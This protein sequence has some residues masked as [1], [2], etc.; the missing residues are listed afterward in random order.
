MVYP[1]MMI[2]LPASEWEVFGRMS[3][4]ELANYLRDWAGRINLERVKKAPP[5]KPTTKKTRRIKDTSPHVSTA[6][7]LN[8][9]KKVRQAK[10]NGIQ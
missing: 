1:G 7:L 6:R 4:T 8:E 2:A 5:R 3:G 9:A 10:A